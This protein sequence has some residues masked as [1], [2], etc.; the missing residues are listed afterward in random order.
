MEHQ[1]TLDVPLPTQDGGNSSDTKT[2]LSLMKKERSSRFKETLMLNRETSLWVTKPLL[3]INHGTSRLQE[4]LM[5]C[6][7]GAPTL[8]GSRFSN[9]NK[10]IS[11]TSKRK[12]DAL[13]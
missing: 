8:N 4:R 12:T 3:L 6:K 10:I 7:F 9:I 11:V 2:L 13:R 5:I 1:P